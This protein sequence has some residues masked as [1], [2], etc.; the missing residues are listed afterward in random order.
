MAYLRET[1]ARSLNAGIDQA[2][3]LVRRCKLTQ[4]TLQMLNSVSMKKHLALHADQ[5]PLID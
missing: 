2:I 1:P 3:R 5:R 4:K